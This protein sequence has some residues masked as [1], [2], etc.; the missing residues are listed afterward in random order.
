MELVKGGVDQSAKKRG[1]GEVKWGILW[2]G[3]CTAMPGHC[4]QL[5]QTLSADNW[6]YPDAGQGNFGK[7]LLDI[8]FACLHPPQCLDVDRRDM[9][10]RQAKFKRKNWENLKIFE[11]EDVK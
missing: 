3:A 4:T 10:K 11:K 2:L 5:S 1:C 6:L 7:F 8:I 9:T